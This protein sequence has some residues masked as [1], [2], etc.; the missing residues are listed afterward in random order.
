[1]SLK[2]KIVI[3]LSGSPSFGRASGKL[4]TLKEHL[5]GI[6]SNDTI[7]PTTYLKFPI[8]VTSHGRGIKSDVIHILAA[9]QPRNWV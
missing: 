6:P 3:L 7:L 2:T 9:G 1:M 8:P 5:P 4:I